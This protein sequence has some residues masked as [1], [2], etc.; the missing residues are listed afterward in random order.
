MAD[1]RE[2]I[3]ALLAKVKQPEPDVLA[4]TLGAPGGFWDT[5]VRPA[6]SE[7]IAKQQPNW[8]GKNVLANSELQDALTA[9]IFLGPA[10][11]QLQAAMRIAG[12]DGKERIF[13][14]V[15]HGIAHQNAQ[16]E[17]GTSYVG[18][19]YRD[20]LSK[21]R[22]VPFG[23]DQ[24]MGFVTQDGRYLTRNQASKYLEEAGTKEVPR[25]LTAE[26]LEGIDFAIV[27]GQ[28]QR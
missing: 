23:D 6:G 11:R 3:N 12:P 27:T 1:N 8:F 7:G 24:V 17:L 19:A 20:A 21:Q 16:E 9:A 22:G 10:G 5:Y 2:L 15:H 18:K 4:R 25:D 14:G 28:K 26:D 13:T